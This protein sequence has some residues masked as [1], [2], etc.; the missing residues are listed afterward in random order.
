MRTNIPGILSE[1]ELA[2]FTVTSTVKVKNDNETFYVA[3]TNEK[4]R[5]YSYGLSLPLHT[6]PSDCGRI[7]F[8]SSGICKKYLPKTPHFGLKFQTKLS[9]GQ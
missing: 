3:F 1:V 9:F 6:N 2:E 5:V 8:D 4:V 7:E